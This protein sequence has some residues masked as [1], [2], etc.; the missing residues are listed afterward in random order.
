MI[1]VSVLIDA[2]S[3][4]TS[5]NDDVKMFF[6]FFFLFVSFKLC[7]MSNVS[8]GGKQTII[9]KG[10]ETFRF[11]AWGESLKRRVERGQYLLVVDLSRYEWYQNQTPDDV[12]AFS[13][14][15]EGG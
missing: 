14:F 11:K 7:V 12:S 1:Q 4:K 10:V 6:F 9:Y 8:C 15:P 2:S 3:K 13:L 5:S